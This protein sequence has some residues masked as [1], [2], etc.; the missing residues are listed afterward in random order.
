M[1][2]LAFG[3]GQVE[4]ENYLHNLARLVEYVSVHLRDPDLSHFLLNCRHN[5]LAHTVSRLV[6]DLQRSLNH[7]KEMVVPTM[8][9]TTSYLFLFAFLAASSEAFMGVANKAK[10]A[11]AFDPTFVNPDCAGAGI[12]EELC[13]DTARRMQRVQV[14]V[15]ETI[16]PLGQ[17]GISYSYWPSAAAS[18]TKLPP[19]VLV[20]G[21]DSSNLE[22]RRLGSR[23]AARGVDTYAVDLLG[24]GYTRLEGVTDFSASAKVEALQ[25]FLGS[26]VGDEFCI[27]GASLGGAAAI[28]TAATN[29][30]CQGLILVDAQGFVDGVGLMASMPTAL[31]KLGV[32]VLK[33]VPLRSSANQMSYY[34][35]ATYATDEAVVIG[36]LHCLRDGWTEALVNFMKS[37]GFAPSKF[38]PQVAVP[39]LV[40]WGRQDTI[41]DGAEFAP[42]FVEALPSATLRWI[43]ESGH[44]PHLEQP[45]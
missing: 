4:V 44:V 25:S 32:G 34:D 26:V 5:F 27:V 22:F 40:L 41:L 20:H 45:E 13:I 3:R 14:Q 19:V 33:S 8:R 24:W 36:R 2:L 37:G 29:P 7:K 1:L 38:V 11:I 10:S 39:S 23:L 42:K 16:H 31:A 17:V 21:F 9:I 30:A 28:E 15:S 6:K 18:S 12:T 35:K 43:E